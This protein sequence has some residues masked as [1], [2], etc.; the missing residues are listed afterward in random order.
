MSKPSSHAG[1]HLFIGI[2]GKQLTPATRRFLDEVRPGGIILFARNVGTAGELRELT[3]SL[4]ALDYRPLI[5][6]D[7]ESGRVNRLR[8]IAGEL[9]TIA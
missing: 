4:R 9:P 8:E 7:Q 2:P 5:A 3:R 6:M 1:Q